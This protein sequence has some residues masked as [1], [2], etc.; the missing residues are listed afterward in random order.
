MSED[1]SKQLEGVSETVG[2]QFKG[3]SD[4]TGDA[5]QVMHVDPPKHP[6]DTR[7][8]LKQKLPLPSCRLH[9]AKVSVTQHCLK[10]QC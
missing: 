1:A 8:T 7:V 6:A 5:L 4:A 10:A 2:Q 9:A 3:L